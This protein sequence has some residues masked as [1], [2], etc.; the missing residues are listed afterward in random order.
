MNQ[1]QIGKLIATCRKEKKL[2]QKELAS[3]LNVTDKSVSKWERGICLPDVSLYKPLCE[4]L[5]ITLNDFFA[6]KKIEEEKYKEVADQNLYKAL[7]N[8]SFTLKEKIDYYTKK[9]EKEHFLE[10]MIEMIIIIFLIIIGFIKQNEFIIIGI[11]GGFTC[12]IWENNRK[13]AYVEKNAYKKVEEKE[14][15]K[16]RYDK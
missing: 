6:G 1:E 8:S 3:I 4:I 14:T 16:E 11:I 10:L 15:N 9:W 12:G 5:G 7:E 13:M 2:T